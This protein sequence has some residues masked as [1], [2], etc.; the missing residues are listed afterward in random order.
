MNLANKIPNSTKHFSQY[1]KI[2]PNSKSLFWT[3]TSANE[4]IQTLKTLQGKKS[5]GHDGINTHLLK[6]LK[7]AI[8]EPL[9]LII[10]KSM[11]TGVIPNK[12]KLAK[13]VP[14]YKNK[15]KKIVK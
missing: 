7:H 5:T 15:D 9:A 11:E 6:G 2:K 14:I 12:L 8:S 13:V 3:P 1:M 10:N 4:I